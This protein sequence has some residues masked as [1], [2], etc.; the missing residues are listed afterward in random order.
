MS[1]D[2][3]DLGNYRANRAAELEAQCAVNIPPA[4]KPKQTRQ[5]RKSDVELPRWR[6]MTVDERNVAIRLVWAI[7]TAGPWNDP[8]ESIRAITFMFSMA[9]K[10]LIEPGAEVTQNRPSGCGIS[11]TSTG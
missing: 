4:A 7:T 8:N 5:R 3:V 2:I 9:Q 6:A 10:A 11:P 1:T